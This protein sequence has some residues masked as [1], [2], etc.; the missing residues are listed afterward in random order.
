ML[1]ATAFG[2]YNCGFG[3][4]EHDASRL[5]LIASSSRAQAL[6]YDELELRLFSY[7]HVFLKRRVAHGLLSRWM[8]TVARN[9][10]S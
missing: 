8:L 3:T 7:Q 4:C 5:V 1:Q 10:S 6:G 9:R 2:Y